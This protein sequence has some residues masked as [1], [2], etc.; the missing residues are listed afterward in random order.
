[1]LAQQSGLS[2]YSLRKL[3]L[4]F[5]AVG[6]APSQ[7]REELCRRLHRIAIYHVHRRLPRAPQGRLDVEATIQEVWLELYQSVKGY[8]PATAAPSTYFA[9]VA[10]NCVHTWLG[11][12]NRDPLTFGVDLTEVPDRRDG[13][14]EFD[15]A[16]RLSRLP[17]EL[18]FVLVLHAEGYTA[19]RTAELLGSSPEA[20]RQQLHRAR[21]KLRELFGDQD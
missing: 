2:V 11:K 21:A 13:A 18:R 6:A 1:M 10:R 3:V 20:V 19:V 8:D 4:A 16:A 12:L 15:P 9:K 14:D 5:Q 7:L 17:L